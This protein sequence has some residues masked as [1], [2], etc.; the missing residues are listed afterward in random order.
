MA[1]RPEILREL[2]LKRRMTLKQVGA[3]VGLNASQIQRLEKGTRRI[4]IDM[5]AAWCGALRIG[6]VELMRGEVRVP[7]IGVVDAQSNI[8]PLPAGSSEWT[9]VPYLVP[10][11][12]RLA[13]VRW[14]NRDRF[15]LMNGSLEFFYADTS[16][17]ASNAWDHRCIIRRSDGTQRMGWL[18]HKDGQMHVNDNAGSVEFN[19][20]VEWASPI[21]AMLAPEILG[22]KAEP[23]RS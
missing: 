12:A 18:L 10:D 4:T 21:L 11:P 9:R 16:G 8:L 17:I 22:D 5:L 13:A 7:V 15:E 20:Q 2:R 3:R 1:I 19:L 14:E 23:P 6:A